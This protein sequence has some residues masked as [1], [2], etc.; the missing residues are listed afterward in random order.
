[1]G[2]GV[3]WNC[4]AESF[5]MQAPPG[6]VNWM[7]GCVGKSQAMPRPFDREPNLPE[8]TKDSPGKPVAPQSLYLTQLA[9]R[10]GPQ[11]LKNIGY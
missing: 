10:L 3:A 7:I 5:V 11:A 8:G 1:M 9:E 4:V 6:A 2:W